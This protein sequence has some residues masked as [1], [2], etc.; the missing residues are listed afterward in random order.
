MGCNVGRHLNELKKSG[1]NNLYGVDIGK[2]PIEES[3][4]YFLDLNDVNIRCSSFEE[5]MVQQ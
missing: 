2:K 1:F 4:K 3:K 5:L